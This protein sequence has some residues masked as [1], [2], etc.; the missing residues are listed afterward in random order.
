MHIEKT[1]DGKTIK[2]GVRGSLSGTEHSTMQ[3]FETVSIT[4]NENPE[5]I[6]LDVGSISFIDSMSIGLLVGILLKCKEKN[7]S[8]RLT[9][10]PRHIEDVLE[11]VKL[12]KLFP[13]LY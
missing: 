12:K 13:D 1:V 6:V 10:V 5:L 9:N 7:I 2:L 3:L 4:L 8:F 11:N